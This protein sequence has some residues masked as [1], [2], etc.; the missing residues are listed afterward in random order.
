[1]WKII[2][3]MMMMMI[4][5]IIIIIPQGAQH[6]RDGTGLGDRRRTRS[7]R[8]DPTQIWPNRDI[9]DVTSMPWDLL[10]AGGGLRTEA[11]DC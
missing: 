11:F 1:M 9:P 4:I 6:S 8:A 5:I 7:F 2:M 10:L 3:M